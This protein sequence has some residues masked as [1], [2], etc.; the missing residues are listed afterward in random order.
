M[1]VDA[2]KAL[3]LTAV[4]ALQIFISVAVFVAEL[5][6]FYAEQELPLLSLTFEP[7]EPSQS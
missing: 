3:G 2:S 5:L 4:V 1:H 6:W 7:F